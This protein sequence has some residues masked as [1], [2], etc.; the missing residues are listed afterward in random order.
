M[1]EIFSKLLSNTPLTKSKEYLLQRSPVL[2]ETDLHNNNEDPVLKKVPI[3]THQSIGVTQLKQIKKLTIHPYFIA[4]FGP[5]LTNTPT[6]QKLPG[7]IKRNQQES[8]NYTR[9]TFEIF[10]FQVQ[11]LRLS[12]LLIHSFSNLRKTLK[13]CSK[14]GTTNYLIHRYFS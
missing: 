5:F 10:L 12:F 9:N 8:P 2:D 7:E 1:W 11:I 6:I 13:E 4:V 14:S 3:K